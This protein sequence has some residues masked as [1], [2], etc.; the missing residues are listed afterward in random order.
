[1]GNSLS[2]ASIVAEGKKIVSRKK[3]KLLAL[4]CGLEDFIVLQQIPFADLQ[5]IYDEM[6]LNLIP[7]ASL[8]C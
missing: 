2:I 5:K 4:R 1:M 8:I 3:C 7:K 6:T